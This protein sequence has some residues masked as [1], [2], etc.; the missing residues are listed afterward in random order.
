VRGL[1][2]DHGEHGPLGQ[3]DDRR[4]GRRFAHGS[5]A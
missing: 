2:A 5:R 1:L 3:P 4:R